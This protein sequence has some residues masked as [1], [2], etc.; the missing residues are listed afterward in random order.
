M[1]SSC[2]WP[3][4]PLIGP[5]ALPAAAC[6]WSMPRNKIAALF[7][8]FSSYDSSVVPFS[9]RRSFRSFRERKPH[10]GAR[11]LRHRVRGG[12]HAWWASPT[13]TSYIPPAAVRCWWQ[14]MPRTRCVLVAGAG[15]LAGAASHR[16]CT[17]PQPHTAA[18]GYQACREPCVP[19]PA[20]SVEAAG[21]DPEAAPQPSGTA[22]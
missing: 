2:D 7:A 9:A 22:A 21:C 1:V 3:S 13:S 16:A 8:C 10:T 6:G 4:T 18:L 19:A 11:C 14:V 12:H 20:P 17:H 15:R 5:I